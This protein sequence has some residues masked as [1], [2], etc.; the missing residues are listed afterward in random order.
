LEITVQIAGIAVMIGG[1]LIWRSV[2]ALLIGGVA[3]TLSRMVLSHIWFAD[4]RN[5]LCWDREARGEIIHF[6]K[7]IFIGTAIAFFAQQADR[8]LLGKLDSLSMLGVYSIALSVATIPSVVFGKLIGSVIFPIF[9]DAHRRSSVTFEERV[10]QIRAA[11]MPLVM[12]G[13]LLLVFGASWFFRLLYS[14][15][16]QAAGWITPLA[17]IGIWFAILNGTANKALLSAGQTRPLAMS[18]LV[19][20]IIS[21]CGCLVGFQYAGLPGFILGVAAGELAQHLY[22]SIV[23]LKY[24]VNIIGQDCRYTLILGVLAGIGFTWIE[25]VEL[26]ISG[27]YGELLASIGSVALVAGVLVWGIIK[28]KP[29]LNI[30]ASIGASSTR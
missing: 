1:A 25:V 22:D 4:V 20:A 30:N 11:T 5:H 14:E 26:S 16:Y 29:M 10:L 2:W 7:W 23:L 18:G 8:L 27:S 3:T 17:S 15:D 6:G 9:A 12:C 24:G 28:I 19:K 13:I 21:I